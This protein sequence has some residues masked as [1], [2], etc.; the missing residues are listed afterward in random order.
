MLYLIHVWL[1]ILLLLILLLL[2]LLLLILL[3]LILL[4]L[5]LRFDYWNLYRLWPEVL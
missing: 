4:L 2:I 5:N 3:L 1:R